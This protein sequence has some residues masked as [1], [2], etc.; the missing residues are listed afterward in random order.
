MFFLSFQI[1]HCFFFSFFLSLKDFSLIFLSFVRSL[2]NI[3]SFFYFS[4]FLS[5]SY[6]SFIPHL[7]MY[8]LLYLVF[9]FFS[10]SDE[11]FFPPFHSSLSLPF[12]YGRELHS[13]QRTRKP[14]LRRRL[15]PNKQQPNK[16]E[17]K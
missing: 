8:L 3:L 10:D 14:E 12:N 16:L 4:F 13:S 9:F 5:F 7:K 15:P 1:Y 2:V 17:R 6:H 11:K